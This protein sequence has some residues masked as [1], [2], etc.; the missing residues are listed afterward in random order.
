MYQVIYFSRG[1]NTQK[2]ANAIAE[3]LKTQAINVN[4]ASL[5]KDAEIIFLGSGCYGGKPSPKMI[6]FIENQ[7]FQNKHMALFGTSGSG[8]GKE[9]NEMKESLQNK[10]ARILDQYS[11]KGRTFLIINRGHP[12]AEDIANAK[13]FAR[14]L[15]KKE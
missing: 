3:E 12:N 14:T 9:L 1:G 8:T 5:N 2:I 4:E 11:C 13:S 6:E 7:N 15:I 10:D